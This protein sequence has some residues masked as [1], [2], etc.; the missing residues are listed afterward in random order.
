MSAGM[1][2]PAPA[3]CMERQ[4]NRVVQSFTK[5]ARLRLVIVA[6]IPLVAAAATY[7]AVS[8]NDDAHAMVK[9]TLLVRLS[10][11]QLLSNL[12]TAES[13]QR[14]YLVT[15]DES[16]LIPYR[17][18]LANGLS[19]VTEIERLTTASDRLG[20]AVRRVRPLVVER[21]AHMQHTVELH[22]SGQLTGASEMGRIRQGRQIMDSLRSVLTELKSED[23]ALL[24]RWELASTQSRRRLTLLLIVGYVAGVSILGSLYL[25]TE[26]YSSQ[27]TR[28]EQ[29][30]VHANSE[31]EQ[32]V[33]ERTAS[34]RQR[35][36]L[37]T[38]FAR[39]VPAATAM[40]DREMKY[41]Q[42]SD[43]WCADFQVDRSSI[44]GQSHY[45]I[46]PDIPDRWRLIH[47]RGLA[48]EQLHAEEDLWR[49]AGHPDMWLRWELRP[50]GNR[51]GAPEGI[52]VFCEDIT[53]RKKI[54]Q[55]LRDQESTTRALLDTA[56]QAILT[57]EE[58]G[59][60]VTANR[61]A[62]DM[63]GYPQGHLAGRPLEILLP[64]S[65]A[66][67]H[68]AHRSTFSANPHRRPMGVGLDLRARRNDGSEFPVE[69]SLSYVDAARGRLAVA[70]VSD[71]TERREAERALRASEQELRSLTASLL[72]ASED[73]R[74]RISRDL[75][76]D[77]TQQL[78]GLSIEIGKIVSSPHLSDAD[79]RRQFPTLQRHV[80]RIANDVRR[81]S[82]GLHPS[83]IEDLGLSAALESLCEEM[84]HSH[85]FVITFCD[86]TAGR[87]VPVPV[88]SCLYRIAQEAIRN[89]VRHGGAAEVDVGLSTANGTLAL[90]VADNGRGFI[91]RT[92]HP[93]IGLGIVSMKE[94]IR[95]VSGQLTINSSNTGTEVV[96]SVPLSNQL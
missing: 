84:S 41:L 87:R 93:S 36:E 76:D 65:L 30:L 53:D 83:I 67:V 62:E 45:A 32:R 21:L 92:P 27:V 80:N 54:E 20:R 34:L 44:L 51:D 47:Q 64:N 95:L 46:F 33:Y 77:V 82:H 66:T 15:G 19:Q 52:L 6:L 5:T 60:I 73:E 58:S 79:A 88:A 42:V 26:R 1:G 18:V 37:L 85:D 38:L 55:V 25:M 70:F 68:G 22:Q 94:R 75:H 69:I 9:Q 14:A 3:V 10:L 56:A 2:S 91:G 11:E 12:H 96:A 39:H 17:L 81:L 50:W 63:F 59:T 61:M 89:A 40:F 57:V 4:Q 48:G 78:A 8:S 13:A 71:I 86:D 90:S 72:T 31:L 24:A 23:D 74:R 49:R 7:W 28:A 29:K 35:E 16:F 43:R